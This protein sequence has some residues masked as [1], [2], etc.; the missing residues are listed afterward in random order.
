MKTISRFLAIAI[1]LLIAV[2]LDYSQANS[3]TIF[4][5]EGRVSSP[6][7]VPVDVLAVLKSD[8]R[9]DVCF[10]SGAAGVSEDA[11]FEA[12]ALDLNGDGRS[13]L[14]I[15]PKDPCLFGA[16]QG[17]FWIFQD[18]P[19]GY[20]K[21]LATEGLQLIIMPSKFNSF[22]V[23]QVSKVIRMRSIESRYRFSKGQY[24]LA[25]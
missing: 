17:P 23:I 19:D 4:E 7:A 25:K 22:H 1:F 11:W 13:D 18:L 21:I 2:S 24:N 12:A 5:V 20:Q 6:V 8:P 3:Q 9:V 10:K 16:N 14:V 15:K